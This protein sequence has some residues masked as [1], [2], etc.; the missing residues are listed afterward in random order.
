MV[1]SPVVLYGQH[2]VDAKVAFIIFILGA[3]ITFSFVLKKDT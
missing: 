2:I 3:M 1:I